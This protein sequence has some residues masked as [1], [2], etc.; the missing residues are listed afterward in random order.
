MKKNF[1]LIICIA[2]L[3]TAL[4]SGSAM[5]AFTDVPDTNSYK[6]AINR[7]STL[8]VINGYAEDNTFRPDNTITR[9][10]MTKILVT[11]LNYGDIQQVPAFADSKSHWAASYIA[12]AANLEIVNGVSETEFEPDNSVTYEQALKMVVCMLGYGDVALSNGGWPE[13]YKAQAS[14]LKLMKGITNQQY[15]Q[16][17]T[18]G[19]IAQLIYNALDVDIMTKSAAGNL[20]NSGK[21]LMKDYLNTQ[22]LRCKVI[23]AEEFVT[24]ECTSHLNKREMA[25]LANGEEIILDFS[26]YTDDVTKISAYL[27]K[28]VNIYY[29]K[30][31][32][33]QNIMQ[34]IAIDDQSVNNSEIKLTFKDIVSFDGRTLKYYDENDKTKNI[35][36]STSDLSLNYN[37]KVVKKDDFVEIDGVN[38]TPTQALKKWLDPKDDAFIYGDVSLI[39][40]GADG[41][42]NLI[43]IYD[44]D[45]IVANRTP[46]TSDYR[47]SDK[48]VT[49]NYLILDPND[50]NYKFTIEKA[51]KKI[52]TTDIKTNDVLLYAKSLDGKLYT[53]YDTAA[54]VTGEITAEKEGTFGDVIT[55]NGK[56]YEISET[57]IKYLDGKNSLKMGSKPTIYVDKYNTIIFAQVSSASADPY[58]Y[59]VTANED[60]DN[61][62]AYM[63]VFIPKTSTSS[64]AYQVKD[65]VKVDGVSETYGGLFEVLKEKAELS[66]ADETAKVYTSG[67]PNYTPYCQVAKVRITDNQVSS[68][69]TLSSEEGVTNEDDSKLV[70]YKELKKYKYASSNTFKDGTATAFAIN[71]NTTIIY[72]PQDRTQTTKYAKKTASNF[73]IGDDY[74]VE[75]YDVNSSKIAGL[76]VLYGS[77]GSNTKVSKTTGY[78]VVSKTPFEEVNDE[79]TVVKKFGVYTSNTTEKIWEPEDSSVFADLK[80][81]DVIQFGY[82]AESKANGRI[83]VMKADDI[84]SVVDGAE[85][86]GAKY[87]W[88]DDKFNYVF[89][90]E[91]TGKEEY[92][93]YSS[94]ILYSHAYMANILEVIEEDGKNILR[95]SRSGFDPST[96]EWIEG[97]EER[98]PITSSTKYLR[99]DDNRKTVTAYA[100]DSNTTKLSLEDL[101]DYKGFGKDCTKAMLDVYCGNLRTMVIYNPQK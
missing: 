84:F 39:D 70:R 19:V 50:S 93:N 22:E 14:S 65:K 60:L 81:G 23:G 31:K 99:I 66:R 48:L 52:T 101:K 36:F 9:A 5:A 55:I 2:A 73:T 97:E 47:V 67:T 41:D 17:A 37:G 13:G 87:N 79:D 28:N 30:D 24:E 94:G 90:N 16:P 63:N 27:G 42:I 80:I 76:V 59:V 49:G 100:D 92:Y 61:N 46:L 68:V 32:T 21:T 45:V 44:Y 38:Y 89:V 6:N 1:S 33:N 29:R 54:P 56:D 43:E 3:I 20:E 91:S 98:I 96:G 75:A 69:T 86:G 83:D 40:A 8:G 53:I 64:K 18:R 71:S 82:N 77:T 72:V 10:E 34:L 95:V 4:F 62:T 7:L 78:S 11:T 85:T 57:C 58:G 25:V 26:D 88:T 74:W 12:T 35:S 51:G 15:P